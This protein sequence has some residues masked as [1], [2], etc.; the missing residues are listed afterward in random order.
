MKKKN[1]ESSVFATYELLCDKVREALDEA[2]DV[3]AQ[4]RRGSRGSIVS[5]KVNVDIQPSTPTISAHHLAKLS[6]STNAD[7][8]S[9]FPFFL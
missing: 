3:C 4:P 7:G 1:F 6:L 5:G 9:S 8:V 2:A